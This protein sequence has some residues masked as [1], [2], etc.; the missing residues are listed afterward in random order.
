MSLPPPP[1]PLSL[2]QKNK[3][4]TNDIRAIQF[5]T[6]AVQTNIPIL[7]PKS[8]ERGIAC[9][10]LLLVDLK[11]WG[12]CRR[13]ESDISTTN[14]VQTNLLIFAPQIGKKGGLVT[15]TS[16]SLFRPCNRRIAA[17]PSVLFSLVT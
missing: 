16:N 4:G 13:I 5:T 12:Q 17:S 10:Q 2:I 1:A 15:W 3:G 11:G 9:H 6:N 14:A 7:D 8:K